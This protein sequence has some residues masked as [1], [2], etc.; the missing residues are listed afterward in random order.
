MVEITRRANHLIVVGAMVEKSGKIL[1]VQ[2]KNPNVYELWNTPAG[3]LE[4]GENPIDGAKREVK[5]ETGFD[6]KINGL[7]GIYIIASRSYSNLTVNK[8]VFRAS[9]VGGKLN[10]PKDELLDVRWF[11]PSE[12][13]AMKDSQLRKIRKEVEDYIKNKNYSIDVISSE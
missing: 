8:I 11:E 13:L 7:L 4:N 10:I 5:E 12:V 1:L 2:E 6:I 9:I 3:W